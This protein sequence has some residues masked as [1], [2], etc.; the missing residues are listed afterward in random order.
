MHYI[1][2]QYLVLDIWSMQSPYSPGRWKAVQG[3][4]VCS[5]ING[6]RGNRIFRCRLPCEMD[7]SGTF[8]LVTRDITMSAEPL[9]P[10]PLSCWFPSSS[11]FSSDAP[12]HWPCWLQG[13]MLLHQHWSFVPYYNHCIFLWILVPVFDTDNKHRMMQPKRLMLFSITTKNKIKETFCWWTR[14]R[15]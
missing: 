11:S 14:P 5:E 4:I 1:S 8:I 3:G 7:F 15:G 12:F 13:S 9:F 10:F 6:I 2:V